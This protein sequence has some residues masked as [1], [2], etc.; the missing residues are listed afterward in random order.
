M[1]L[2]CVWL[3]VLC[4]MLVSSQAAYS[5]LGDGLES[6]WGVVVCS[7]GYLMGGFLDNGSL[8][9]CGYFR[10]YT[11]GKF[12]PR[13]FIAKY[14]VV[15]RKLLWL[16]VVEEFRGWP[17]GMLVVGDRVYVSG[18]LAPDKGFVVCLDL[19][20]S[21]LWG[22]IVE[23]PLYGLL[24]FEDKVLAYGKGLVVLF[25]RDG[26]VVKASFIE[27][28]NVGGKWIPMDF[29]SAQYVGEK[30]YVVGY[31]AYLLFAEKGFG[32]IFDGYV[33]CLSKDLE[34]LWAVGFGSREHN[35]YCRDI[36]FD[37]GY[38]YVCGFYQIYAKN[39]MVG[40]NIIVAKFSVNGSLEWAKSIDCN[41]YDHASAVRVIG[42]DVFVVGNTNSGGLAAGLNDFV[43]VRIFGESDV[44]CYWTIGGNLSDF[45]WG[46]FFGENGILVYGET[47]IWGLETTAGGFERYP[48]AV[49][50]P[51][52]S[53][54]N[55]SWVKPGWGSIEIK[56]YG[57]FTATSLNFTVSKL[58]T[59]SKGVSYCKKYEFKLVGQ[60]VEV[61]STKVVA[62][63]KEA[64]KGVEQVSQSAKEKETKGEVSS[65]AKVCGKEVTLCVV[66]SVLFLVVAAAALVLVIVVIYYFI[67]R[68]K[69]H[70]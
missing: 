3:V 40:E 30:I 69:R 60:K 48:V 19:S 53:V 41:E 33:V 67:K 24:G 47:S 42:G 46:A 28:R 14:D 44:Y 45:C 16:K 32:R 59:R 20:G 38:L 50:W 12:T 61:V 1:R 43:V 63:Q 51:L 11:G 52:G 22:Y 4:L 36:C 29:L 64:Q 10:N 2:V 49:Y 21:F 57:N 58:S 35:E 7:K 17:Y 56:K 27:V 66:S 65:G 54:G 34:V 9:V 25:S 68:V 18:F 15:G 39:K 37:N 8:Y 55:V 31:Q 23:R 5:V 62:L 13:V 26:E 6:A 70:S